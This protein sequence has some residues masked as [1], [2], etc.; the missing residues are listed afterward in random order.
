MCI[1]VIKVVAAERQGMQNTSFSQQVLLL[2][3]NSKTALTVVVVTIG[4]FQDDTRCQS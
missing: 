3:A 4:I 2:A 1:C